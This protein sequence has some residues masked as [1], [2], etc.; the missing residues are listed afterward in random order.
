MGSFQNINFK[1][2]TKSFYVENVNEM[3]W[4]VVINYATTQRQHIPPSLPRFHIPRRRSTNITDGKTMVNH[5]MQYLWCCHIT[6]EQAKTT[7]IC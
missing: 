6:T 3:G 1:T 5:I 2:K 7:G 4:I